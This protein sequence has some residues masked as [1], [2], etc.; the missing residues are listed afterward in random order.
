[1]T[2]LRIIRTNDNGQQTRGYIVV[3]RGGIAQFACLSLELPWKN[4]ERRVSCIPAGTYIARKHTSPK[5]GAS[6]H[7]TN[8]P[9]R[10]EILI[11]PANYV[12]QLLG[13]VAV[14]QYSADMNND[15]LEDVTSSKATM[16]QLL[17]ALPPEFTVHVIN[18]TGHVG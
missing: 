8:V 1:M 3:M 6:V 9:G 2:E 18:E 4:N 12:S 16:E 5:F 15:G 11:H 7:I 14:G 13:C 10:S 17:K